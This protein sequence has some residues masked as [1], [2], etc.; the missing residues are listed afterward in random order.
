[1][2]HN[3]LL[4]SLL[5]GFMLKHHHTME[6]MFSGLLESVFLIA[7]PRSLSPS[8]LWH[9]LCLPVWGSSMWPSWHLPQL[10]RSWHQWF[11]WART[12]LLLPLALLV[13]WVL[14]L[15]IISVPWIFLRAIFLSSCTLGCQTHS[16]SF[17]WLLPEK[18]QPLKHGTLA[19]SWSEFPESAGPLHS[20]I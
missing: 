5:F 19:W 9:F 15:A 16:Q 1:M 10:G 4:K 12:W 2:T 6:T 8:C 14:S 11:L 20:K 13:L 3:S 17:K 18:T 7:K